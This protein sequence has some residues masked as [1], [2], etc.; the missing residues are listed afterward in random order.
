MPFPDIDPV[1][2]SFGPLAITWYSLS[3]VTGI[4]IGWYYAR[5]IVVRF[6]S[7][8]TTK[9][10]D[11]FVTWVII[12]VIIGGRLGYV[13]FYDPVKY[14]SNPLDILK[15]YK[16]GMSFHG[17]IAG[18]VISSYIYCYKN[19]IEYLKFCDICAII[20]P[21]GLFL[22][23]IANF[24]NGELYGNPTNVAWAV[25]FPYSDGKPRHPSQLYEAGLE[26]IGL[27][28]IAL[29]ATYKFDAI[30][31]PGRLSGL[32]LLFYAIFRLFIELFR[33]PDTQI[34]Y[35]A[36]YFT[37]GQ[38]LSIPMLILG[39]YLLIRSYRNYAN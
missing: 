39:I 10:L 2:I 15:T 17:G 36:G 24:I 25:I 16:G 33:K 9:N 1:I 3:Y 6:N 19:S 12:G 8:V 11:D 21:I 22:G 27:F 34:G 32:F 4:L 26:G 23:R 37:M 20:A 30:Q 13:L 14:L 5:H 18:F 29:I 38:L 35:I 31:K 28:V 7:T